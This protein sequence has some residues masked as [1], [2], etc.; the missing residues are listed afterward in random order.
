[1]LGVIQA[2]SCHPAL[3]LPE[4]LRSIMEVLQPQPKELYTAVLISRSLANEA[5]DVLLQSPPEHALPYIHDGKRRAFYAAEISELIYHVSCEAYHDLLL[6]RL[7][8]LIL[9]PNHELKALI[10][11]H[12]QLRSISIS[13]DDGPLQAPIDLLADFIGSCNQLKSLSMSCTLDDT[14]V[15]LL[16]LLLVLA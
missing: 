12:P 1:L 5:L 2:P 8:R 15:L 9:G 7:Q 6:P 10:V 13:A 4:I 16:C 3:K 11:Q 14:K